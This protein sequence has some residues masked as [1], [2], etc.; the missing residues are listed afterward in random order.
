MFHQSEL[1][2][3]PCCCRTIW[4]AMYPNLGTIGDAWSG[5]W[6]RLTYATPISSNYWTTSGGHNS[7]S[8]PARFERRSVQCSNN[9]HLTRSAVVKTNEGPHGGNFR[10]S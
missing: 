2:V 4:R 7:C 1:G 5:D 6:T 9:R 10:V 3:F 8:W